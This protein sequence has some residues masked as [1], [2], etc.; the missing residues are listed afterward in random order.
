MS[1][2]GEDFGLSPVEGNEF[3]KPAVV[4]RAGGFLDSTV[5]GETGV[6]IEEQSVE[7]VGAALSALP[8]DLDPDVIRQ[9][10]SR[11]Q[12]PVFQARLREIVE[13]THAEGQQPTAQLD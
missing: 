2:S 3:G 8:H 7:S 6:F 13:T 4:L 12:L 5:E 1:A 11:F 9:H 10:A